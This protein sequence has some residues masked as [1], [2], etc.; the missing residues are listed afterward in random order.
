MADTTPT[1][2]PALLRTP[3]VLIRVGMQKSWLYDEVKAGRFPQPIKIGR[4]TLYPASEV[5]D[6]VS[7]KLA[8]REWTPTRSAA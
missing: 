6:W 4:A 1:V 7:A 8:G 2:Q 3:D 5:D